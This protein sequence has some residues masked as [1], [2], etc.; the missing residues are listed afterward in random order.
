[1]VIG[2]ILL[3]LAL[4]LSVYSFFTSIFGNSSPVMA[5]RGVTAAHLT[6]LLITVA[7]LMLVFLFVNDSFDVKYVASY[8]NL[9]LPLIYKITG[10]WAGLDGSLLLWGWI[11]AICATLAVQKDGTHSYVNAVLQAIISFFLIMLVFDANPFAPLGYIVEDGDGLNPLL[12]NIFMIV[13]PPSLYIG[14]VV[15]SVPF[16]IVI[17]RLLKKDG[18]PEKNNPLY[19]AVRNWTLA[20][21]LFLT[22]GNLLGAMWAY[23]ELGWGGFWAWDPVENAGIMPWFT[24][25]AF[26]HTLIIQ[27]KRGLL[28]RWNILLVILTFL[29]TIFGTFITRSGIIS[30]V[31]S[32][33]DMTIGTYFMVFMAVVILFSGYLIISRAKILKSGKSIESLFSYEG[34]FYLNNVVLIFAL[35]GIIWGTMLPLFAQ[36]FIGQKIE[37]G[38]PFFNKMMAPIGVILLFLT[39]IGPE[40]S[41]RRWR[42]GLFKK[43]FMIPSIFVAAVLLELLLA[44]VRNWFSILAVLG[45]TFIIVTIVCELVRARKFES[46]FKLLVRRFSRRYGGYIVHLGIAILFIGIAGS[47]YKQEYQFNLKIGEKQEIGGYQILLNKLNWQESPE[48]RSVQ[49]DVQIFNGEK[50]VSILR[51][52]LFLHKNQPKPTAEVDIYISP[53]K[54]IYLTLAGI[55]EDEKSGDFTMTINPFISFVWLGGFVMIFGTVIALLPPKKREKGSLVD[56]EIMLDISLDRAVTEDFQ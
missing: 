10:L 9:S 24:A 52:A 46:S 20:A 4:A 31:H 21:W 42:K 56:E 43:S 40:M 29:L 26:L 45:S 33:S 8:S 44:G 49:S 19:H 39:G 12:R 51:P 35:V 23:V 15:L 36:I 41:W 14:Y 48:M 32:F 5:K 53:L 13:H 55:S 38:P 27:E 17:A 47:P 11:L 54:D 50:N 6:T 1:M 7:S 34:A 37:V 22:I 18:L 30:S 3:S 25:T 28:V 2:S 16:A